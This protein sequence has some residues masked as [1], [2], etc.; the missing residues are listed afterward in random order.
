M[1][2]SNKQLQDMLEEREK[3]I[4]RLREKVNEFAMRLSLHF[5]TSL[6]EFW[7]S[8]EEEDTIYHN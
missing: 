6:E 5:G 4:E 3:E 8:E 2:L 7:R 1:R